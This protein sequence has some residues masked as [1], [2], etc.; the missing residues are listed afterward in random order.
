MRRELAL[1]IRLMNFT[2][3]AL[4]WL[5]VAGALFVAG[6]WLLMRPLW[7]IRVVRVQGSLQHISASALRSQALP[8]LRG[9]WFTI[10]LAAAQQAFARVPWVRDAVVQ[11]VWPLSLL[12]T[13][14]AQ[15]PVAVWGNAS[16]SQLVDAQG[17]LFDANIGEVQDMHLPQF[18]GPPGSAQ[19]VLQ[20]A[21]EL[22]AR[23]AALH[24]R[25]DVL[26]LGAEGNWRVRLDGGPTLNLGSDADEVAF[27]ARLQRFVALAPQVQRQYG[28]AIVSADLRYANGFAVRLQGAAAPAT[29]MGIAADTHKHIHTGARGAR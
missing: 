26:E 8:R 16:A 6:N 4:V 12:V 18:D 15:Q 20:M 19:R 25:V 29:A 28:R 27:A 9:N 11:R 17:A 1:D 13:L 21:R 7:A 14:Q 5:F 24:W 23:L 3:R 2:S 22:D 10:D